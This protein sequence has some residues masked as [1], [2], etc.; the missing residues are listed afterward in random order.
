[1]EPSFDFPFPPYQVQT[2]FM[3]SLYQAL[4]SY[5]AGVF[6]SP[7]GTG[8]SLSIICSCFKWL[9]EQQQTPTPDSPPQQQS[10]YN[11]PAEQPLKSR[12]KAQGDSARF[13]ISNSWLA[14]NQSFNPD[15]DSSQAA[16]KPLR[17]LYV[18][19][20]HTQLDQFVQEIKRTKWGNGPDQIRVVRLASR[21]H[22]CINE[23]LSNLKSK[24]AMDIKCKE[25]I[26]PENHQKECVY[27]SNQL[28]A[29]QKIMQEVCDIEDLVRV[30]KELNACPYFGSRGAMN[31]AEVII[32]PYSSVLNER[33]R[34][35]IG[36][37]LE[38][39]C[40][41]ID[42]A[43]NLVEAICSAYSA[44]IDMDSVIAAN[45]LVNEYYEMYTSI[46][47]PRT[48]MYLKQ[49]I[50]VTRKLSKFMNSC[51]VSGSLEAQDLLKDQDLLRYN[52]FE[53]YG[54]VE[55]FKLISKLYGFR[56]RPSAASDSLKLLNSIEFMLALSKDQSDGKVIV[57]VHQPEKKA[58]SK[59]SS[60]FQKPK[61]FQEQPKKVKLRYLLLDPVR[62]FR[63]ILDS[64][65][66]VVLAGGTMEPRNEFKSLFA[67]LN[68]SQVIHFS[69]G[70]VIPSDHLL[71]ATVWGGN[72]GPFRFTYENRNNES[73]L[74]D[75][76][77]LLDDLCGVVP[78]GIVCFVPSYQFLQKLETHLNSSRY[79]EEIRR[80]KNIFFDDRENN[81]LEEY[82]Q[83]AKQRG[84]L[85]FAVVRGK[86]SEGINFSD[87][88]GRCVVMV[89]L[90][91]LSRHE[92]EIREKMEYLD[93][94]G[95]GF[96]GRDYYEG[97]CH[98]AINQ[99]IGRS[100]RHH[101]DYSVIV[102]IDSRHES[103]I[104]N[105]PLWMQKRTENFRA[106]AELVSSVRCFFN[107]KFS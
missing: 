35:N 67:H 24:Q 52:L 38:N 49:I 63:K 13:S 85:L 59:S 79:S 74:G 61:K 92:I 42:E 30:G 93:N 101:K 60:F 73:M 68:S 39:T 43:H 97:A 54:W 98:K 84:A 75:L 56:A 48:G 2:Q 19:R 102:L 94:K 14:P 105:R 28:S 21:S 25:I 23:H 29:R 104:R 76:V 99:S 7:T 32:A 5:K 53:I 22:L 40:V 18:S 86:L 62:P 44:E 34:E 90:P 27:Y 88:L 12:K 51:Q 37:D 95:G 6:E 78:N 82:S 8:K 89:G 72:K 69:C 70:H 96:K 100:I 91:Y 77:S 45:S 58:F 50:D 64:S 65:R 106:P 55:E 26:D 57:E 47:I 11:E 3:L 83:Q 107:K 103:S 33:T 16:H 20:T 1:M 71:L 80:K 81:V 66:C 46:L 10:F 15:F 17:I 4:Q 9:R 41:V 31:E 36:L 87:E